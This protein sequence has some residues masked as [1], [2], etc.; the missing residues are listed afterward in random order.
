LAAF[1]A[2]PIAGADPIQTGFQAARLSLA[3]FIIPFVFVYHPAVLYKLQVAFEWFG[4][5][6]VSSKAMIDIA[7]VSWGDFFWII[8]AF[9]LAMWLLTSALTGYEKNK[10]F[11]LERIARVAAGFA[12]LVPIKSIALPALATGAFLIILHRFLNGEPSSVDQERDQDTHSNREK[13]HA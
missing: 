8:I 2:A 4:E 5:E 7:T 9:T 6:A 12:V 13:Q 3:G 10:L 1:A 11:G